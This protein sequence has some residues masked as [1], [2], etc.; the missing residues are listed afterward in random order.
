LASLVDNRPC[1][2]P[3]SDSST[4]IR[5]RKAKIRRDWDT[6]QA[7]PLPVHLSWMASIRVSRLQP[8]PGWVW[9]YCC[10]GGSY[11]VLLHSRGIGGHT[12]WTFATCTTVYEPNRFEGRHAEPTVGHPYHEFWLFLERGSMSSVSALGP[13]MA[14]WHLVR[15][16]AIEGDFQLCLGATY[17]VQC[18]VLGET[19]TTRVEMYEAGHRSVPLQSWL[20]CCNAQWLCSSLSCP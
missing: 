8:A 12:Q 16:N 14:P 6:Y 7:R 18:S 2:Q 10:N 15:G 4:C 9:R 19:V 11:G 13:R 17:W 1:P 3:L 5:S 20:L